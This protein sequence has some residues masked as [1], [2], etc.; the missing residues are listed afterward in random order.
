MTFKSK[1]FTVRTTTSQ[2]TQAAKKT[3]ERRHQRAMEKVVA[4]AKSLAEDRRRSLGEITNRTLR[5][6][7]SR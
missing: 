1:T 2:A 6:S 3:L 7:A 4:D 5:L